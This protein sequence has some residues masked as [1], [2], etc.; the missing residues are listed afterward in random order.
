MRK[1]LLFPVLL[2]TGLIFTSFQEEKYPTIKN[3]A[4]IPESTRKM[5]DVSGQEFSL[6]D[7]KGVNGLVV[8]FSCNTCPFVLGNGGDSEGWESR[9]PLV[10]E[11]SKTAKVGFVLINSNEAKRSAGDGF[12]DMVTRSKEKNY[13]WKYLL[14]NG[15]VL[16]NAFGAKTTPHAFL[17]DKKGKLVYRGAIDDNVKN[18][19][20]VKKH[21][22]R[23][24][25][26]D[27][28]SSKKIRVNETSPQ[29]CS[30]KR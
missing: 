18:S 17:F 25:L 7:C 10:Y 20:D 9:Y 24:A 1:N 19:N 12:E 30:I 14:D 27:L 23:D 22:L 16:A 5:K 13:Q 2:I 4:S 11:Y 26:S 29:G 8:I 15:S 3:G 28:A 21:Y 6:N